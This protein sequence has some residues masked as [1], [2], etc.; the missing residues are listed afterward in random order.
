MFVCLP[1][2]TTHLLQPL[3]VA[4]YAPLKKYW[5]DVLTHWKRTEGLK[6]KTLVKSSF[7]MLLYRLQNKLREKG[8]E[9]SNLI[10]GFNKCGL[11]PVN[12]ERPKCRLPHT[13]SISEDLIEDTASSADIEIL[14]N[15]RNPTPALEQPK[16]KRKC[17]VPPGKRIT[18]DY[19][20]RLE[21]PIIKSRQSKIKTVNKCS[22]KKKQFQTKQ[23]KVL[24]IITLE[25]HTSERTTLHKQNRGNE[26]DSTYISSEDEYPTK[27]KNKSQTPMSSF[28]GKGK[29]VKLRLLPLQNP[30]GK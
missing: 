24:L 11:Y 12:S 18:A 26:S 15:L 29:K 19:L 2:K 13:N 4:L 30:E 23:I 3:D 5:R 9:S 21:K 28:K 22:E 6:H 7:P 17:N 20:L 27:N 1:S 16:R 14:T 25:N 10:A 8:S